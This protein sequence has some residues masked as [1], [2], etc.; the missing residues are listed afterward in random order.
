MT[1]TRKSGRRG[2]W[3]RLE[4]AGKEVVDHKNGIEKE[5][6]KLG[7]L[8]Y[9]PLCDEVARLFEIIY[10]LLADRQRLEDENEKLKSNKMAHAGHCK[11][12]KDMK[13]LAEANKEIKRLQK[14]SLTAEDVEK[15]R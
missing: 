1:K 9:F 15:E 12:C 4:T 14:N 7:K 13:Q 5:I 2:R 3:K 6:K 10:N 11:F 8:N